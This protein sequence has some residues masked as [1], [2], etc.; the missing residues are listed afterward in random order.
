M[1]AQLFFSPNGRT[2]KSQPSKC[3]TQGNFGTI[4]KCKAHEGTAPLPGFVALKV[5]SWDGSG[6]DEATVLSER[7][8]LDSIAPHAGIVRL[9]DSWVDKNGH[10]LCMSRSLRLRSVCID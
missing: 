6:L 8:A 1:E 5:V 7:N 4:H 2:Y 9:L 3:I 10:K